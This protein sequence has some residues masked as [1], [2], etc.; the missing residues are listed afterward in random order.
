MYHNLEWYHDLLIEYDS[1]TFDTDPFE[2]QSDALH[3]IYPMWVSNRKTGFGYVELPYT[4]PQDLTLFVLLDERSNR[5]W[6]RKLDWIAEAGG[7][8][9]LNTHPDYM[10]SG[11]GRRRADEYPW[12]HYT[13][14]LEYAS[15]KY[16][17]EYWQV[18]PREVAS[19]AR[20]TLQ[21]T[22]LPLGKKP[23]PRKRV[24]NAGARPVMTP[25]SVKEPLQRA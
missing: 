10:H 22:E 3:T 25:E 23:R 8:A 15:L 20:K 17:G 4:L 16:A 19:Y 18:L 5:I 9:L 24:R 12:D 14:F 2:P 7:M 11:C 1:S 21:A 13:D 6:K